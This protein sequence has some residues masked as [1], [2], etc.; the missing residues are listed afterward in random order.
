MRW[1]SFLDCPPPR[2]RNPDPND[3]HRLAASYHD[4]VLCRCKPAQDET[5]EYPAA[6]AMATDEQF[7]V[8]AMATAREQLEGPAA[9]GGETRPRAARPPSFPAPRLHSGRRP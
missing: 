9:L 5:G 2:L 6:E 4:L 8:Y 7:F 3:L 1:P